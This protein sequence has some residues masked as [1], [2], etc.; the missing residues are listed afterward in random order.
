MRRESFTWRWGD[1]EKK[2]KKGS[3][4]GSIGDPETLQ[5]AAAAKAAGKQAISQRDCRG[6]EEERDEA[7]YLPSTSPRLHVS[8]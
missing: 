1:G 8:L 4:P 2:A 5:P 6:E 7:A 3:P